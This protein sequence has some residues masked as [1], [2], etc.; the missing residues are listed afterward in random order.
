MMKEHAFYPRIQDKITNGD[1]LLIRFRLFS[2]PY[3][4][5]WGWV[6]D[7]LKINPIVD[8]VENIYQPELKVFP[9]PGNG[10]VNIIVGNVINL[11]PVRVSVYNYAGKCII[12]EAL[13]NE[14]TITLNLTGN[15]SGLYLI[16]INN[17][18]NTSSIKYNLIK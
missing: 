15:P 16:V 10:M 18:R 7:D 12:R 1:S 14:E 5:G 17:G 8:K 3:A 13:F 4:N 2:D 11:K 9:N 6:I